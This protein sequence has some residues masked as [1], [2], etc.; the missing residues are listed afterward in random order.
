MPAIPT[1]HKRSLHQLSAGFTLIELLIVMVIIGILATIGLVN[2]ST[3]RQK[4]RDAK[5]KAD[6]ETV[7]KSL[8]AYANDH[9][10]YPVSSS[11]IIVCDPPVG[12]CAWGDEFSDA[13]GTIYTAKLPEDSSTPNRIYYYDSDGTTYHL[14]AALENDNDPAIDST[15]VESCGSGVTCNYQLTSSNTN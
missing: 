1:R 15:I 11:G 9:R 13:Q 7:A 5:R 2:F 6:L 10:G 3:A 4:A 8:E 14:F 12:T